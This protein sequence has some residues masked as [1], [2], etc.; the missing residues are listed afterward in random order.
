MWLFRSL[1]RIRTS[2][3]CKPGRNRRIRVYLDRIH[4]T[5]TPDL[6]ERDIRPRLHSARWLIVLNSP[7]AHDARANWMYREIAEFLI[8]PQG[9]NVII[10]AASGDL[11]GQLPRPL[12]SG[13]AIPKVAICDAAAFDARLIP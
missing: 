10:A 4:E 12:G 13:P 1:R 9:A 11:M 8:L 7:G 5:A 6:W 2:D 3:P